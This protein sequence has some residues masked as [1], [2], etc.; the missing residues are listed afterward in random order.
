MS[1]S[2]FTYVT[3]IRTTPEKLW[4]ALTGPEFT[5]QFWF[6][7]WQECTW[8]SGAP[9]KLMT[10]DGRIV[11][12]GEV[13]EIEPGRKLVLSWRTNSILKCVRRAIPA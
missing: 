6:E 1:N 4:A 8:K 10:P 2:Q 7:S 9:W 13:L 3:Y 12:S 11:D 5:R